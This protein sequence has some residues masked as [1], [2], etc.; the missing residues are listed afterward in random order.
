[1]VKTDIGAV[2]A[3]TFAFLKANWMQML[4]WIGGAVIIV[5]LL[6]WFALGNM[7]GTMMA[8][9]NDPSVVAGAFGSIFLFI[10]AAG[11]IV[12]AAGLLCW[13][14]GLVGG[15]PAGDIG[16][17]LGAGAA[18]MLALTVI[19]IATLILMYIV[20]LI[21]GLFAFALFG[22]SGMSLESLSNGSVSGGLMAFG[23]LIYL[24]IVLFFLWFF[25][26]LSV[27]GPVMAAQRSSN[28][29]AAL[30]ESWKLTAASQ[31]TIVGFNL[32]MAILMVALLFVVNLLFSA[33]MGGSIVGM[34]VLALLVYVPIL[35]LSVS[36]PAGVYRCVA[37][38]GGSDVFA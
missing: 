34:L 14:T 25:G 8:A 24:A 23:I 36:M 16:W 31:W 2:F 11:I 6:G 10:I 1:M 21:V 4:M 26:R 5:A 32:L 33:I 19:Y 7:F 12:S 3:E 17:S 35:L 15:D 37:T 22:A 29:F 28:P 13:R 20:L 27:A 38:K 18:Y 9:A 30:A